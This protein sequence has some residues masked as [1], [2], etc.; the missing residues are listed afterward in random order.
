[1][2]DIENTTVAEAYELIEK[3]LHP[4]SEIVI[5]NKFISEAIVN[6]LNSVYRKG[7]ADTKA[8]CS[9]KETQIVTP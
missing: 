8:I 9:N 4:H 7:V 5:E 3:T 1:M 2:I 6:A